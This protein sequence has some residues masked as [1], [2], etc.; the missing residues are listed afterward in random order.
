VGVA[1]P[2]I[3]SY[4][5]KSHC[6]DIY[7][8]LLLGIPLNIHVVILP[9]DIMAAQVRASHILVNT[10][11]EAENILNR[12]R[13][14]ARFEDMA[15]KFSHCPSGKKGGDLGYF[16]KGQMVKPFEDVAFRLNKGEVS[17]P[18]QTQFGFHIIFVTDKR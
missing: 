4:L 12:L 15:R 18:V 14:G 7:P 2:H 16:G 1:F 10:K 9:R 6:P 13:S 8:F 5:K 3:I 17:P 11:S